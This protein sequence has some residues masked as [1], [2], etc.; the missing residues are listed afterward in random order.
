MIRPSD[1]SPQHPQGRVAGLV[2]QTLAGKAILAVRRRRRTPLLWW[3]TSRQ[4][5]AEPPTE[6]P[7]PARALF[8]VPV[9]P[10]EWEPLSDTLESIRAYNPDAAI[11]VAADGASDLQREQ[12]AE[13]FPGV[14]LLRP[15]RPSG[16]PPRLSP[17]IAWGYRWVLRHHD[18]EVLC[19]IDTDALVTGPGL[20]DR[21][22]EAIADPSV[23]MLGSSAMRADGT[24]GDT[25]YSAWV[26]A[27]ERRWSRPVRQVTKA[28]EENGWHGEEAHGGVYFL[29]RRAIEAMDASGHLDA[30]PPWWSLIGE[31]LWFSL[32]VRAA[33][34]RIAS[35]GGPGE[36]T[37]SAQGFLPIDKQRV[38]DD[39]ILAIHSVR[40][41]I[42]GED[43]QELRAFFRAA[44]QQAHAGRHA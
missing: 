39:G 35:F 33:G 23:G 29:A 25:S 10:G 12:F 34:L 26:I 43:E 7:P 3:R 19:K 1:V 18:F 15:P 28:A 36:P 38:L 6:P 17:P 4:L 42:A 13:R 41:G 30:D 20:I 37:A 14:T 9:G 5:R 27:H 44:R 16:G 8:F 2:K 11:V 31:D 22:L 40:R 24:P 21:A 32:G